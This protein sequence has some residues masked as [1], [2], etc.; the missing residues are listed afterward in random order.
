MFPSFVLVSLF[1]TAREC[2]LMGK[3]LYVPLLCA[4]LTFALH[5]ITI[6][7]G[8]FVYDDQVAVL[9]NP[10]VLGQRGLLEL[11][12]HDFW[13]QDI[14]LEVSLSLSLPPHLCSSLFDSNSM[15]VFI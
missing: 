6:S 8:R 9:S 15:T 10:D 12:R 14:T 3:Y 13:G 5:A 11:F 4:S 2:K 7:D 1:F